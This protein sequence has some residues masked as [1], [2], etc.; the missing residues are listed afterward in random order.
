METTLFFFGFVGHSTQNPLADSLV[1]R[2][3]GVIRKVGITF[4]CLGIGMTQ[5]RADDFEVVA[6]GN[7]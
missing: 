3:Q 6:A 5:Q 4:R 2:L 7:G 1:C